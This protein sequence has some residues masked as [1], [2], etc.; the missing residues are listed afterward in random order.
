MSQNNRLEYIDFAKGIGIILVIFVHASAAC[1]VPY[2][3][4]K[5]AIAASFMP[6][7]FFCSGFFFRTYDSTKN[8]ICKKVY[9]LLVPFLFFHIVSCFI[10][11]ILNNY[12]FEWRQIYDFLFGGFHYPNVPLWFVICLF[13]VSI[14]YYILYILTIK[15]RCQL[16]IL[17]FVSVLLGVLGYAIG[18]WHRIELPLKF[19]TALTV[20]PYYCIG[21]VFSSQTIVIQ[22]SKQGKY[23]LLLAIV[24]WVLCCLLASDAAYFINSYSMPIQNVYLAAFC[25]IFFYISLSRY[26]NYLPLINFLGRYSLIILLTH[27]PYVQ[28]LMPLLFRL[29]ISVWWINTLLCTIIVS[30]SY[31]LFVPLACK[32]IPYVIG[33]KWEGICCKT[34]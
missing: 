8:F 29:G 3:I 21:H 7:F 2:F 10:L 30:V 16:I 13:D 34:K 11:P 4:F 1:G 6:L 26:V 23:L 32:Y 25:G 9:T 20:M 17:V 27:S 31:L 22:S 33:Q 15:T 14:I 28:R 24:S 19:D 18:M 12:S 5:D